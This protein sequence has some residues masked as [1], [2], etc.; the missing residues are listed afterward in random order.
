MA[1]SNGKKQTGRDQAYR[2]MYD[3]IQSGELPVGS[4]TS[5]SELIARL[6][7]GR[8][9]IRDAI[10]R[11]NDEGLVQ[12]VSRK[13]IF[14]TGVRAKD[15]K[16][17]FQLRLAI[18][19]LAIDAFVNSRDKEAFKKLGEIV[20][21]QKAL[22]CSGNEEMFSSMDEDFHFCIINILSNS[23]INHILQESRKQMALYGYN[24]ITAHH[25]AYEST[26]EH[27]KI[28]QFVRDHNAIEARK[29]M[30]RHLL[31]A[32]NQILLGGR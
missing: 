2:I 25:N 17:M 20:E 8:S 23:R 5:V 30:E 18:E 1:T 31:K 16:E 3:M 9:P 26:L 27:E 10:L 19:F 29:E 28:Y 11:L 12:V 13:G 6:N 24:A 22:V 7:I 15:I 14:I 4:V 21:K 32:Q